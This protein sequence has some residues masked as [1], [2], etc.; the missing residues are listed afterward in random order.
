M[1]TD[2]RELHEKIVPVVEGF[3]SKVEELKHIN[4]Q[5]NN[6]I[7]ELDIALTTKANKTEIKILDEKKYDRTEL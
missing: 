7:S 3:K 4:Y 1:Y 5:L 6:V 2:L